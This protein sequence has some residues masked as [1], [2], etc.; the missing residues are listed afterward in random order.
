M[1]IEAAMAK[2]S[3]WNAHAAIMA[4][5]AALAQVAASLMPVCRAFS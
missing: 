1:S 2:Q 3:R 4:A 5:F